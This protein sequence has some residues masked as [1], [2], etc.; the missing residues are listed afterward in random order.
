MAND[1]EPL[2]NP[3]SDS[4]ANDDIEPL[5]NPWSSDDDSGEESAPP[6]RELAEAAA[7][8]EADEHALVAATEALAKVA[9]QLAEMK[10]PE[11]VRQVVVVQPHME[12]PSFLWRMTKY[13]LYGAAAL[14]PAL[15]FT[16]NTTDGLVVNAA[17]AMATYVATFDPVAATVLSTAALNSVRDEETFAAEREVPYLSETTIASR[18]SAAS[19]VFGD[20]RYVHAVIPHVHQRALEAFLDE[21]ESAW[22]AF[23]FSTTARDAALAQAGLRPHDD[24]TDTFDFGDDERAQKLKQLVDDARPYIVMSSQP[25]WRPDDAADVTVHPM[26]ASLFMNTVARVIKHESVARFNWKPPH[27]WSPLDLFRMSK[28][29]ADAKVVLDDVPGFDNYHFYKAVQGLDTLY[30]VA[31]LWRIHYPHMSSRPLALGVGGLM[32]VF[33]MEDAGSAVQAVSGLDYI[34]RAANGMTYGNP[35]DANVLK[36]MKEVLKN[37]ALFAADVLV[38]QTWRGERARPFFV[39]LPPPERQGQLL[40]TGAAADEEVDEGYFAWLPFK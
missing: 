12:Q 2:G 36:P 33:G 3:W 19:E 15:A 5:G 26:S 17:D 35:E 39:S 32:K 25:Q 10:P 27:L 24:E 1:I 11:P 7:P 37:A 29:P 4:E 21:T 40:D 18:Q 16:T 38:P 23:R 9:S 34:L 13:A 30:R 22:D 14:S 20:K 8:R 6:Q 31:E 28:I